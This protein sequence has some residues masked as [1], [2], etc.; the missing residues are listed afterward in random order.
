MQGFVLLSE[1]IRI[2]N[3]TPGK[4]TGMHNHDYKKYIREI[5]SDLS[6]DIIKA[7]LSFDLIGEEYVLRYFKALQRELASE[8]FN[9]D[10]IKQLFGSIFAFHSQ[11]I[12]KQ[13]IGGHT[14]YSNAG[15]IADTRY[16]DS[17]RKYYRDMASVLVETG[18]KE[19]KKN[20]HPDK[21]KALMDSL[22][23]T[24][25]MIKRLDYNVDE[26]T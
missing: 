13:N 25:N 24:V 4:T 6:P 11:G 1:M 10:M 18:I 22:D 12:M 7:T 9:P 23:L 19:I 16:K 14:T 26:I 2:S 3:I 21:D 5:H 17:H 8:I 20:L 15:D